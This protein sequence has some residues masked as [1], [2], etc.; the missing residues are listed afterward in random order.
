MPE[1]TAIKYNNLGRNAVT[2]CPLPE[3]VWEILRKLLLHNRLL[4]RLPEAAEGAYF[5]ALTEGC[6]DNISC[7]QQWML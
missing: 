3:F 2:N 1:M 7:G 5:Q 4:P 6:M